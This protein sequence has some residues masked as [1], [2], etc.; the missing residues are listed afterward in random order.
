MSEMLAEVIPLYTPERQ[1][2]VNPLVS[3]AA[4]RQHRVAFCACGETCTFPADDPSSVVPF[5]LGHGCD[6][7]SVLIPAMPT[8]GPIL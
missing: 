3:L 1:P 8:E 6:L 2:I 5:I 4:T 7:P